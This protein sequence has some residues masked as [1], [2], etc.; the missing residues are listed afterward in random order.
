MHTT[1]APHYSGPRHAPG[2]QGASLL[3]F[4]GVL[5]VLSTLVAG[6]VTLFRS[7]ANIVTTTNHTK[8]AYYMAESGVRYLESQLVNAVGSLDQKT[9]DINGIPRFI[10]DGDLQFDAKVYRL[11]SLAAISA[12][13][14]PANQQFS[15][16]NSDN[17]PFSTK[18][19]IPIYAQNEDAVYLINS[20]EMSKVI[21]QYY[22]DIKSTSLSADKKTLYATVGKSID[23]D[24]AG[25]LY[26]L[27]VQQRSQKTVT[28]GGSINGGAGASIFPKKNG[29][30]TLN[31]QDGCIRDYT[32]TERAA[33]GDGT[34]TFTNLQRA[35]DKDGN[36]VTWTSGEPDKNN[37]TAGG[38]E[39]AVKTNHWII[40][41]STNNQNMWGDVTG[42][43][44]TGAVAGTSI[45]NMNLAPNFFVREQ[46][47]AS[48]G[49]VTHQDPHNIVQSDP[50]KNPI[51]MVAG[52]IS[53]GANE[54]YAF[55][56]IWYSGT[57]TGVNLQCTDGKCELGQ[58]IRVFYTL[59]YVN[60]SADGFVFALIN[61]NDNSYYSVGGDSSMGEN[62]AWSGDGRV[63]A[64]NNG[65]W[66]ANVLRWV[67]KNMDGS[68]NYGGI[69]PPK[70]GVEFDTYRNANTC[71]VCPNPAPASVSGSRLD[72]AS[73]HLGYVFWGN[74]LENTC[75]PSC[76]NLFSCKDQTN[77]SGTEH[78]T[79]LGLSSYD[80]N[81]HGAGENTA[82]GSVFIASTDAQRWMRTGVNPYG[83]RHEIARA[84]TAE[85][86]GGNIGKYKYTI[87]TWVRQC[88]GASCSEYICSA[89]SLPNCPVINKP[90][91]NQ[92]A[93][94]DK[95]FNV[96]TSGANYLPVLTKDMYLTDAE[97][98]KMDTA[99]F[100]FTQGTGA[101][102]QIANIKKYEVKFRSGGDEAA[103]TTLAP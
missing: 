9:G 41:N 87:K 5:V 76:T 59:E 3:Y 77:A 99:L 90:K 84:L 61:G 75:T 34:Y 65:A 97:H 86:S 1:H 31:N 8:R 30:L 43:S 72:P 102:T 28:Q 42:Y 80:D 64:G 25:R 60:E 21:Q 45:A 94:L 66:H 93:D 39:M 15:L 11:G 24:L 82:T 95:D 44:G 98:Q 40:L 56:A 32:Y 74:D 69:A 83:I 81:K 53:L 46:N 52:G 103:I 36:P 88:S 4:I 49:S 70:F 2:Q 19:T 23:P 85:T 20:Q 58:G 78:A 51:T 12:N 101:S 91:L 17:S 100:G 33:N 62:L 27:A 29:V 38:D 92:L 6:M 7:S 10:V 16:R 50:S 89:V 18:F 55:G 37:C 35:C 71:C 13:H 47:R 26:Y 79:T 54:N 22:S 57:K 14:V 68:T 67:S 48:K 63:Y 96:T 73:D